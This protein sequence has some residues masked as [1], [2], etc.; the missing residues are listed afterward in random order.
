M[1]RQIFPTEALDERERELARI[2]RALPGGEPPPALDARILRNATDAASSRRRPVGRLLASVGAAWGIGGAAAAVLALGVSWQMWGPAQQS[3]DA[4]SAPVAIAATE[5]DDD[6]VAVQF[7]SPAES[8]SDAMASAPPPPSPPPPPPPVL[9]STRSTPSRLQAKAAAPVAAPAPA[10]RPE[11]FAA[12][13]DEHVV[14]AADVETADVATDA[15]AAPSAPAQTLAEAS[16]Q[17]QESAIA[18]AASA[19]AEATGA[20]SAAASDRAGVANVRAKAA[21]EQSS[22][23]TAT[24][25]AV[26]SGRQRGELSTQRIIEPEAWL[27]HIRKLR[28]EGKAGDARISLAQFR[29]AHPELPIPPDL[30]PLLPEPGRQ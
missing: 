24:V 6:S 21:A 3:T 4:A 5:A 29:K 11:P 14:S 23:A 19:M 26:G 30:R 9:K 20:Q 2:V 7:Q 22:A 27:T 17:R 12:D 8:A 16:A 18:N 1:N 10:P 15:M 28:A 13:A 25:G